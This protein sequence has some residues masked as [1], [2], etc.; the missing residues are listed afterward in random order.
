LLLELPDDGYTFYR[1]ALLDI[2]GDEIWSQ[3]K[4]TA[5]STE[6]QVAIAVLVPA[7]LLA[8]GDYQMKVS[9][10]TKSRD[11]E[12]LASYTFRALPD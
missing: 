9:G 10:V 11:L 4:L 2:D 6:D 7:A 1:A 3:S 12:S 5:E 8:H